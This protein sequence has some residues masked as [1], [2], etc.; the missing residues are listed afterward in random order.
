MYAE[1][2]K[3]LRCIDM[4]GSCPCDYSN[5]CQNF[6]CITDQAAAAIEDLQRELSLAEIAADDNGRQVEQAAKRN[7][8]LHAEW[9]KWVSAAEQAGEPKRG[10]WLQYMP[11]YGDMWRCSNCHTYVRLPFRTNKMP[12]DFCPSCGADMRKMEV[13]E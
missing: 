4:M 10:E 6:E 11:E 9:E 1:L 7:A 3:A 2:I 13:Q 5:L 8:E 12:Y